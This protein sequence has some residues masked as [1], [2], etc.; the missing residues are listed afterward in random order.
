MFWHV[1]ICPHL[2]G[3]VPRLGPDREVPLPGGYSTLGTPSPPSDLTR[4]Y[5][6]WG[7]PHLGSPR[8]DLA[9]RGGTPPRLTDGV[10]DTPRSLCLLRSCRTFL[11]QRSIQPQKVISFLPQVV[12]SHLWY[13]TVGTFKVY[14]PWRILLPTQTLTHQIW[15][16]FCYTMRRGKTH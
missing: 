7:V 13:I 8:S 15:V 1:S 11:L 14:L 2:G 5:P 4:G 9:G 10:L 12:G 16:Y 3:G 6:C